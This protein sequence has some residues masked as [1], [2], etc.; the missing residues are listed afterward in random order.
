MG[1]SVTGWLYTHGPKGTGSPMQT[2]EAP[3]KTAAKRKRANSDA[4]HTAKR[5]MQCAD[6]AVSATTTTAAATTTPDDS[7][8][9]IT[10]VLPDDIL[11]VIASMITNVTTRLSL[12]G[13]SRM[14]RDIVSAKSGEMTVAVRT[15]HNGPIAGGW[16]L[17]SVIASNIR[18]DADARNLTSGLRRA[19]GLIVTV[20]GAPATHNPLSRAPIRNAVSDESIS[21]IVTVLPVTCLHFTGVT[22]EMKQVAIDAMWKSAH[23]HT[24]NFNSCDLGVIEQMSSSL[25]ANGFSMMV[26]FDDWVVVYKPQP[27]DALRW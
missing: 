16:F 6:P 24:V 1:Y 11:E 22:G 17:G 21:E 19:V 8:A 5:R 9:H 25:Q 18:T 4:P 27:G 20:H 2:M 13:V 10:L 23:L 15:S 7:E 14:F 3:T 12:R 26:S